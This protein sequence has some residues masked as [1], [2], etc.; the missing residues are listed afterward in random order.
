MTKMFVWWATAVVAAWLLLPPALENLWAVVGG[1]GR[2]GGGTDEGVAE[3]GGRCG[4]RGLGMALYAARGQG[5]GSALIPKLSPKVSPEL[6]PPPV[7]G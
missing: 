3:A 7:A 4:R 1:P 6:V 5:V 2:G